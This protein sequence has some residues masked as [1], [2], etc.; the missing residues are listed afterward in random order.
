MAVKHFTKRVQH[1]VCNLSITS[2]CDGELMFVVVLVCFRGEQL[3]RTKP[4]NICNRFP[5]CTAVFAI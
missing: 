5:R 1:N 3:Q 4:D 2:L